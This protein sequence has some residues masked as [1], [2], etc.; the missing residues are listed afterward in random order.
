MNVNKNKFNLFFVRAGE[1][2]FEREGY[3]QEKH[4]KM[5]CFFLAKVIKSYANGV[6]LT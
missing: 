6:T 4:P 5:E 2:F 1:Y 3:K